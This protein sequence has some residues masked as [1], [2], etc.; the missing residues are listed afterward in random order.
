MDI[1]HL[2]NLYSSNGVRAVNDALKFLPENQKLM[3]LKELEEYGFDVKWHYS[4][5]TSNGGA[6]DGFVMAGPKVR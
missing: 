4:S 2:A 3:L 6:D 1:A 5:D